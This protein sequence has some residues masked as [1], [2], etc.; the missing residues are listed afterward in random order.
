MYWTTTGK[1]PVSCFCFIRVTFEDMFTSRV[2]NEFFAS[3]LIM[4]RCVRQTFLGKGDKK[5]AEQWR[6]Y[7]FWL[8]RA[9]R[10]GQPKFSLQDC[11]LLNM[12]RLR[13]PLGN[14]PACQVLNQA[15]VAWYP[16][17]SQTHPLTDTNTHKDESRPRC[18]WLT[19]PYPPRCLYKSSVNNAYYCS[20][21]AS[22]M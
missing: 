21:N 13:R 2:I 4:L 12:W 22:N 10:S 3:T 11:F 9:C 16:A 17:D 14:C 8:I 15:L 20:A 5:I 18:L 7:G 6:Y 19:V 1:Q